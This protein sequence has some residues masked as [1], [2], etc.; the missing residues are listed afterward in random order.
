[1]SKQM[2]GDIVSEWQM[3]DSLDACWMGHRLLSDLL[4]L[5]AQ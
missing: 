1:M 4:S 5:W 2:D 3:A